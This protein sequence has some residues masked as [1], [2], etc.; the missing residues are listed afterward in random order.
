M[1]AGP[2]S[3]IVRQ[4]HSAC[5]RPQPKARVD[6]EEEVGGDNARYQRRSGSRS[7][8]AP[9]SRLGQAAHPAASGGAAP[10][11]EPERAQRGHRQHP[12]RSKLRGTPTLC[13]E[14][15]Q[16]APGQTTR[17]A[18]RNLS[19]RLTCP[20]S[21]R[22]RGESSFSEPARA[23]GPVGDT[24]QASHDKGGRASV[25][26]PDNPRRGPMAQTPKEGSD[27]PVDLDITQRVIDR[28]A[29]SHEFGSANVHVVTNRGAVTLSGVLPTRDQRKVAEEIAREREGRRVG[30][31]RDPSAWR[32]RRRLGRRREPSGIG[33]A[34]VEAATGDTSA[35]RSSRRAGDVPRRSILS[36]LRLARLGLE[37]TRSADRRRG[38]PSGRRPDPHVPDTTCPTDVPT[39]SRD[40][41]ASGPLS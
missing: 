8:R 22:G 41:R 9:A 31:E 3:R 2:D 39:K 16:R 14:R 15:C 38:W 26:M 23:C 24:R 5:R 36:A 37:R 19:V 32:R 28:L 17:S 25:S 27:G 35:K 12:G 34:V 10:R 21:T 11:S 18:S 40:G 1:Q 6:E 7:T 13:S 33:G 29:I 4:S 30:Q 20:S